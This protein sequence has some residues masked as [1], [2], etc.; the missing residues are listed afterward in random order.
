MVKRFAGILVWLLLL[1][2]GDW[3][4]FA[5][6]A[7]S[8]YVSAEM[9]NCVAL[10]DAVVRN[11]IK[12]S[13]EATP[14]QD[15]RFRTDNFY[16]H[17]N[18]LGGVLSVKKNSDN[19]SGLNY[20][21]DLIL[22]IC[23]EGLQKKRNRG[24]S[25]QYRI[26]MYL[27]KFSNNEVLF[28]T[29]SGMVGKNA[30]GKSL[31]LY[32]S[33]VFRFLN[34]QKENASAS[35]LISREPTVGSENRAFHFIGFSAGICIPAGPFS[36]VCGPGFCTSLHYEY[37]GLIACGKRLTVCGMLSAN[38]PKPEENYISSVTC[39]SGT[40][41]AG[42][43]FRFGMFHLLPHLGPGIM[44]TA[45]IRNSDKE[46]GRNGY[47]EFYT[48]PSIYGAVDAGFSTECFR[49]FARQLCILFFEKENTGRMYSVSAGASYSF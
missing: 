39:F 12:E 25:D 20:A 40:A 23:V 24:K 47:S 44:V 43:L 38:F 16:R 33:M 41:G 14:V 35:D 19:Q 9:N 31:R 48:D 42:Y 27:L 13:F 3:N 11:C 22:Y 15:Y 8:L 6:D 29:G 36:E 32:S 37:D 45:M 34:E 26:S 28:N 7:K 1:F 49:I 46:H 10:S 4:I 18:L 5:S 17:C 21:D 30:L 2:L